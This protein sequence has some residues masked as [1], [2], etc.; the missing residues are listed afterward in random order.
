MRQSHRE[1]LVGLL[2]ISA[3]ISA[4]LATK[5]VGCL[6]SVKVLAQPKEAKASSHIAGRLTGEARGR[7]VLRGAGLEE[8][9]SMRTMGLV[10]SPS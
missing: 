8:F 3:R 5:A 7:V 9:D 4:P 10:A 2:I 1:A 6:Q